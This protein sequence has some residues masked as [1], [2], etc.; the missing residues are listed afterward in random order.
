[1]A[2]GVGRSYDGSGRWSALP[3]VALRLLGHRL[4]VVLVTALLVPLVQSVS[5]AAV[6]AVGVVALGFVAVLEERRF[7]AKALR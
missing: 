3:Y 2:T 7:D 6:L 1:M 5:P 4:P